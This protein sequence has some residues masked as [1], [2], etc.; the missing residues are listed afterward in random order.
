MGWEET[1]RNRLII[2]IVIRIQFCPWDLADIFQAFTGHFCAETGIVKEQSCALWALMG[3]DTD[4][5]APHN[6]CKGRR[7]W[8]A[9]EIGG[10][11]KRK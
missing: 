4:A 3:R 1:V 5:L 10:C 7:E 8:R 2:N 11:G 6:G 9:R